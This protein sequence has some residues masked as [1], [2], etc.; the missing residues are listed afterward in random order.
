MSD[1]YEVLLRLVDDNRRAWGNGDARPT[2]WVYPTSFWRPGIDQIAAQQIVNLESGPTPPGRYW[3]AVSI[4][5]PATGQ[6][7]PVTAGSS[8]SPDT[9]FIGPLKVPLS[10]PLPDAVQHLSQQVANFGDSIQL[11]GFA[12]EPETAAPGESIQVQLLWQAETT[13]E[14]DYT[15][16]IHLLDENNA[17]VTGS[18]AQPLNGTYPTSIWTS[19]EQVFDPHTLTLPNNLAPGQYR[20]AIGLYHQPTGQRL[21]LITANGQPDSQKQLLLD[22]PINVQAA[23]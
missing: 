23:Q 10:Q 9:F 11:L 8:D 1:E 17:L 5:N 13:P 22:Q 20:L 15:V 2:D 16:F 12:L 18:D 14:T 21:P 4:F 6:L 19:G 7:L 3:L